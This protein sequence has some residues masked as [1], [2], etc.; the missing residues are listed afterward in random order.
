MMHEIDW[1]GRLWGVWVVLNFVF[2]RMTLNFLN[3]LA[4]QYYY[5]CFNIYFWWL[6]FDMGTDSVANGSMEDYLD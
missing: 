4:Y 3:L 2:D 1:D 6:C 5:L